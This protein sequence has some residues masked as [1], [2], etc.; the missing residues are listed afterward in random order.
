MDELTN[1]ESNALKWVLL[2]DYWPNRKA[3]GNESENYVALVSFL[4]TLGVEE[5]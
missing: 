1:T 3:R 2:K 4:K 5:N